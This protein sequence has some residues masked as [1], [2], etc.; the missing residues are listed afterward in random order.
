MC[1]W[2][3]VD[4]FAARQFVILNS[5]REKCWQTCWILIFSTPGTSSFKRVAYKFLLLRFHH[6]PWKSFKSWLSQKGT[7][8]SWVDGGIL[9]AGGPLNLMGFALAYLECQDLFITRNVALVPRC[10]AYRWVGAWVTILE[11]SVSRIYMC[12]CRL[13]EQICIWT[14]QGTPKQLL[15]IANNEDPRGTSLSRVYPN[16][17]LPSV[18]MKR[19]QIS[20]VCSL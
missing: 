1:A 4:P 3:K 7:Y 2:N 8:C 13:R 9:L 20:S 5:S 12:T 18:A 10:F 6:W 11:F 17:L 15:I 19:P 14:S 16:L